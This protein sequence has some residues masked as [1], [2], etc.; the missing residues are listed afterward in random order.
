MTT[1]WFDNE[2][3]G[4]RHFWHPV[5]SID[6]LGGD[7]PHAVRL[8]GHDYT[9]V[10]LAGAWTLLPAACPHRLAPLAAGTVV[11]DR[12]QCAYH[13]WCF[14][15]QGSCVHIPALGSA[16]AIPPAAHAPIG[17]M[18]EEKYGLVWVA[19]EEPLAPIPDIPEWG[20][21]GFGLAVL[22]TQVWNASA[23]QMADNFLDVAHF[24]FTHLGTIGDPDDLEV[25]DYSV[26]RTDW[27]FSAVHHH[28]SKVLDAATSGTG[29]G[30]TFDRTMS[31][32]CDAPHHVRLHIDYGADGDLVLMFFHQ[33]IDT[34][35]TGVY[36]LMLAENMA[37]GRM[38]PEEHI[39]F[40]QAVGKEDRDLLEQLAIKAVPL[41]LTMEC[42]TR[43]D[44]ITVELRRL[45]ADIAALGKV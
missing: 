43:A 9:L 1:N 31:F 8:I 39:S 27:W 41:D 22:P 18:A 7:G 12:L 36:L 33:P 35:H 17:A 21:D 4:L 26:D 25:G 3:A 44:K 32:R 37:D 14:D 28:R 40:Q 29:E 19:L 23:A 34:D 13:G 42:H 45:L 16:G 38:S 15:Q 10:R 6:E 24:P 5:G 20:S 30:E 11:N 2:N